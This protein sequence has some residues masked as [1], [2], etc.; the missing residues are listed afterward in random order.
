MRFLRC[1][2]CYNVHL[3]KI[4]IVMET[5]YAEPEETRQIQCGKRINYSF[6]SAN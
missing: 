1:A 5:A 6:V 3:Y 4:A 2:Q